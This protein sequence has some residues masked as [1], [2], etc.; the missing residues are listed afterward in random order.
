MIGNSAELTGA[1][2]NG[3]NHWHSINWKQCY[4][5]VQRLQ[6]RIVKATQ[7]GRWNKVKSLQRL[8]NH[9]FTGK[10]IAVRQV[11]ENRGKKTPGVDKETWPTP[12]CKYQA[13]QNLKER[14]YKTSPLRRVLIPKVNGKYRPLS[15]PTMK[16]RAMQALYSLSLV[17]IAETTGDLHS[18]GFR[19]KRSTADAIEQCYT[20]LSRKCAAQWILEADI[21]GCFDTIDHNWLL[22][23]IPMDKEILRK[24]L[25]AGYMDKGSIYPTREGTPQGGI[26]SP[27]LANLTLDGLGK[28]LSEKYPMKISSRKP[29]HK[30]NFIRY[31]DDFVITGRTKEQLE[32]EILPLVTDFLQKRGLKL[33][34]AKTKITHID[35]GF[36]FLGQNVRKYN[37]KLLIKP[38]K[39][40]VQKF[41]E[42]IREFTKRNKMMAQHSLIEGLNR[43]IRGW[44]QY[45]RHVVSK[46]T[47]SDIRHA[48]WKILW[49]WGKS[50]HPNKSAQWIKDKYFHYHMGSDWWFGCHVQDRKT[51]EKRLVTL[52]DPSKIPIKRH[53][54]IKSDCN[55]Y[56]PIWK[57]YLEKRN[58]FKM[59]SELKRKKQDEI[60]K[61]QKGVCPICNQPI[62]MD[63]KWDIHHVIPKSEGGDNSLKN[64]IMLHLTCH[65]QLHSKKGLTL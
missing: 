12:E 45:H 58:Y 46:K 18:Y 11:T 38:S 21:E 17:P 60:W 6:A 8:L 61:R 57:P 24:W 3:V 22:T 25:K 50:R 23:N 49:Y 52:Y 7:E 44:C 34:K 26:I 1:L 54:K 32:E 13:I 64:L 30:V 65:R 51:G 43:K 41:L 4:Q 2:S 15:I 40:S 28:L 36:D 14:G 48:L 10:A 63:F 59:M 42:S 31:A 35:E 29:A 62:S 9:S 47:F 56:D 5:T 16:D 27:L 37:G 19:S 55:P 33:S 39:K 20:V 53:I